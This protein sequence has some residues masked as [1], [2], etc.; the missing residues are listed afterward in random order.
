M[1]GDI[2][3]ASRLGE[4]ATFSFTSL[5]YTAAVGPQAVKSPAISGSRVLLAMPSRVE[6]E[7]IAE[8]LTSYGAMCT[9]AANARQAHELVD[10]AA[11]AGK[12]FSVVIGDREMVDVDWVALTGAAGGGVDAA[13]LIMQCRLGTR[14]PRDE[15]ERFDVWQLARKP[16]RLSR[17]LD[18]VSAAAN[19]RLDEPRLVA[20]A[21]RQGPIYSGRVLVA[22][23]N[24][25]NQ[26]VA[27]AMV[28]KLGCEVVIAAD[29]R[30]AVDRIRTGGFDLVFMD[31]NMPEIDGY[32]AVREVRSWGGDYAELPIVALTADVMSGARE[33]S[34]MAGM[35]DHLPKP[36]TRAGFHTMLE[37]W[38]A[39][40]DDAQQIAS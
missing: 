29:G 4:G 35:N 28:S 12:P 8:M 17:L 20:P 7:A 5:L 14:V 19:G 38:L 25:T 11:A 2:V 31:C 36:V 26:K 16:V 13:P 21:R 27:S 15:L 34:L 40:R 24:P 33:R 6:R 30:E 3:A 22:E 9:R 18:L 37:R 39:E 1:G 10:G 32:E 23:D